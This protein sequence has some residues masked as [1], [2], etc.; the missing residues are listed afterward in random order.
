MN[1]E[2]IYFSFSDSFIIF[3]QS[4]FNYY[5]YFGPRNRLD[6]YYYIQM[7]TLPEKGCKI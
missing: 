1:D 6:R 5:A 2:E 7:E 3:K 4:Y